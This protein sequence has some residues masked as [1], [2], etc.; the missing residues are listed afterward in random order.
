MYWF[1]TINEDLDQGRYKEALAGIQR[2]RNDGLRRLYL[3]V[4]R[5]RKDGTPLPWEGGVN[6]AELVKSG[7]EIEAAIEVSQFLDSL[8]DGG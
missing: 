8:S 3:A 7:G 6:F 1:E 2:I 5:L 4:W